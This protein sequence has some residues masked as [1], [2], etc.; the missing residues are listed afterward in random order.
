MSQNEYERQGTEGKLPTITRDICS[1]DLRTQ[2]SSCIVK[3]T[4]FSKFRKLSLLWKTLL[5]S[6]LC[7]QWY[8]YAVVRSHYH[9]Q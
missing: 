6:L 9:K 4:E 8:F 7:R 1:A 2:R 3:K 5:L